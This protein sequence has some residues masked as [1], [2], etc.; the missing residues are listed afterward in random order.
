MAHQRE[1]HHKAYIQFILWPWF[2]PWIDIL[3]FGYLK[4]PIQG[5]LVFWHLHFQ[6]SCLGCLDLRPLGWWILGKWGPRNWSKRSIRA[7]S[8]LRSIPWARAG[9]EQTSEVTLHPRFQ[10]YAICAKA[11]FPSVSC[12]GVQSWIIS[13]FHSFLLVLWRSGVSWILYVID[14][15]LCMCSTN[16]FIR[17]PLK[18]RGKVSL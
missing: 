6:N 8:C 16:I 17:T 15:G 2:I 10:G 7:Q 4:P 14:L 18:E 13:T 5:L 12:P 1:I 3:G 11:G 9:V